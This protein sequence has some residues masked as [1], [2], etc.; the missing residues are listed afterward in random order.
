[1]TTKLIPGKLY[2]VTCSGY[3]N[4]W[5]EDALRLVVQSDS[6]KEMFALEN[7]TLKLNKDSDVLVMYIEDYVPESSCDPISVMFTP[8]PE[9]RRG[10]DRLYRFLI[11]D[12]I[13]VI[14]AEYDVNNLKLV[15]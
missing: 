9:S 11:N 10:C 3:M 14:W 8:S 5:D 2:K 13:Y 7:R 12:S 4:F 6:A 1:M 15:D